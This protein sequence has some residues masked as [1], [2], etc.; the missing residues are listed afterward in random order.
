[1]DISKVAFYGISLGGSHGP[2]FLALEPRLK[3]AALISAGVSS[4]GPDETNSWNFAPRVH[5]PVLM[6]GGRYDFIN[7]EA[8]QKLLLVSLGRRNRIKSSSSSKVDTSI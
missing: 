2:R 5:S 4:A 7:N 8:N 3:A 6:L 1:V